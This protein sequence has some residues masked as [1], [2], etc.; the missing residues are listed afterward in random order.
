M[1]AAQVIGNDAT[2]AFCGAAGSLLEL[3]VMMPV[4]AYD[5][6]QSAAL[7]AAS[8]RNLAIAVRRRHHRDRER[9]G[10][11]RARSHALHRARAADRVRRR[12]GDR[13]GGVQHRPDR[14][15]GRARAQRPRR[16]G[17]DP[18][19]RR[20]G[21][22]PSRSRRRPGRRLACV[23]RSRVVGRGRDGRSDRVPGGAARV[24]TSAWSA[25]SEEGLQSAC[26][27]SSALLRSRVEKGKLDRGGLRRDARARHREHLTSRRSA[28][29]STIIE[30]VAEDRDVKR[31]VYARIC[32]HADDRCHHRHELVD[33]RS[34]LLEDSV[35]HPE[36]FLNIHFFNPALLMTLVEVVPGPHTTEEAIVHAMDFARAIGKTPVRLAREEYGFIA[37]RILF[38]AIQEAMTSC[39]GGYIAVER[40]R[41][42]RA[43][44][45]GMADGTVRALRPRR[46]RRR[47]GH[48][49]RGPPADRRSAAGSRCALL[50]DHVA[51]GE[52]GNKTGGGFFDASRRRRGRPY[53]GSA[54]RCTP[55]DAFASTTVSPH[56]TSMATRMRGGSRR[57]RS[58]SRRWRD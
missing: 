55:P 58:H 53:A 49:R 47:R 38:I 50:R 10:H 48:P 19:A 39:E 11:G 36:R 24:S 51:R 42:R 31:E 33:P 16:G 29:W 40:L 26:A 46:P 15:R 28:G 41:S 6:L 52:L 32:E 3:N 20:R 13:Q 22:D 14:A 25:G 4:A 57:R 18:A 21:D 34:S 37:N 35:T 27:S 45:T 8:A 1:V 54:R 7:L 9:S 2:V 43:Q 30:T 5:L 23:T 56:T 17:V 44:R 12:G